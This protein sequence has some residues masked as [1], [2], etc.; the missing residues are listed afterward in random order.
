MFIKISQTKKSLIIAILLITTVA[1]KAYAITYKDI[2]RA[3]RITAQNWYGTPY[4]F[5]GINKKGID[6][7]GFVKQV[8]SDV[9]DINLPR[10]SGHQAQ[11]GIP[12]GKLVPG[13]LVFFK[14]GKGNHVGIYI[15]NGCFA[16]ASKSRGVTISS[17]TSYWNRHFWCARRIFKLS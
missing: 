4:I 9:F 7:S 3:L 6:C 16:H 8:Y 14:T 1:A 13:D 12:V 11:I 5:G 2:E 17:F 15:G 10:Y